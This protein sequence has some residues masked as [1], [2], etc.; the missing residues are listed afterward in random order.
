MPLIFSAGSNQK[1]SKMIGEIG[2]SLFGVKEVASLDLIVLAV[3]LVKPMIYRSGPAI[4]AAHV[5]CKQLGSKGSDP[6]YFW[7]GLQGTNK[8]DLVLWTP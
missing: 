4:E 5:W 7:N 2:W 1:R 6:A 3:F 8:P